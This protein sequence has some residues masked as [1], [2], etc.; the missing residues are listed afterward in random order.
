MAKNVTLQMIADRVGVSKSTVSDVLRA[1]KAKV[2]VSKTT[3]D[4]IFQAVKDLNYVPNAAARALVTGRTE[5]VGFLLSSKTSHGLANPFY[6]SIAAGVQAEASSK[7]YNCI[8]N[9]Y[10]LSSVKEFVMP[11]KVRRKIVDG[12]VISGQIE[13]DVLQMFIDSG[14]PFILVG[15][16]ADFPVEGV[17]SVARNLRFDWVTSFKHLCE[18]GHRRIAVGGIETE[19]GYLHYKQTVEEFREMWSGPEIEFL[20]YNCPNE[21]GGVIEYA[22]KQGAEWVKSEW[23]P[24]AVIGHDQWCV[25]F[26]KA[27]LDAGLECPGDVSII[28]TCD[29]VL[30]KWFRPALT[31]IELPLYDGGK[32]ATSLLIDYINRDINWVEANRRSMNIWQ[33]HKLVVRE[34]TGVPCG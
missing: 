16:N 18:L 19:L 26:A 9:C 12:I 33:N 25:G 30:C 5:S 31:A 8:F 32:E 28:S 13:E 7:G 29:T 34:S 15:E 17:L 22:Y 14:L 3:K 6:A 10:D 24:S 27:I 1:R 2:K 21:C 11:S 23:R 20:S 4:K